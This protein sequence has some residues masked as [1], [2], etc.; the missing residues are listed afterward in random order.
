MQ[1][2]RVTEEGET[3]E[4]SQADPRHRE[5]ETKNTMRGSRKFCQ[6]GP[7]LTRFF[8]WSGE[9]GSKHHHKRAII[10]PPA[11][12]ACR[13]WSN[14]DCWLGYFL[15]F[16]GIRTSINKKTYFF[17][18]GGGGGGVRTLCP[19]PPFWIR[20]WIQTATRVDYKTRKYIQNMPRLRTKRI[21]P[22]LRRQTESPPPYWPKLES[23]FISIV[24]LQL[25]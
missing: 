17:F 5:E 21:Q 10:G 3:S 7:T 6:R 18:F 15:I 22:L 25:N 8:R 13:W 14:I 24:S 20:A 16:Q 23:N 4:R 11:T 2:V 9:V 12:L 1:W 19:P